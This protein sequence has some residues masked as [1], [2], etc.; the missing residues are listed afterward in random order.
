MNPDMNP[1]MRRLRANQLP[2]KDM[3]G[4]IREPEQEAPILPLTP[5]QEVEVLALLINEAQ[6]TDVFLNPTTYARELLAV[7]SA[8]S[9]AMRTGQWIL[10]PW[11]DVLP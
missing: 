6:P 2:P 3:T 10:T 8:E 11:E 9:L 1:F 4:H 7:R 5:E